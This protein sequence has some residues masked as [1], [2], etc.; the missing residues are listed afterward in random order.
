MAGSVPHAW[1]ERLCWKLAPTIDGYAFEPGGHIRI[2]DKTEL[3]VAVEQHGFKR[4]KSHLAHGI[5]K[6]YWWLQCAVWDRREDHSWVKAY[7]RLLVWD[8]MEKPW[9]TRAM[10]ALMSPVMGKSLVL[11]FEGPEVS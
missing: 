9:L 10:D 6:P 4:F 1:P 5:H 7:H 11:Y 2:F 8:L 3:S